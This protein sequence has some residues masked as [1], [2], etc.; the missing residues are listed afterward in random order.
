MPPESPQ[1]TPATIKPIFLLADSQLLFW[2][3]AG[4]VPFLARVRRLLEEDRAGGPQPGGSEARPAGSAGMAKAPAGTSQAGGSH[5]GERHPGGSFKA[6]YLGASNG[7]LREFYELFAGAMA[8]IGI[9]DCRMVPAEPAPADLAHFDAAD[10]ILLAG[11]SVERGW[12]AFRAS[13]L[14]QRIAARYYGG[15]LLI[16][17]SAGAVQLGLKAWSDPPAGDGSGDAAPGKLSLFDTLRLVPFVI[18]AHDEPSWARLLAAVARAGE[19]AR[20]YGIPSGG[21]ALYHP[22]YSVEPVRHA[23]VEVSVTAEGEL[24]QSL[25]VPGAPL[26]DS[27]EGAADAPAADTAAASPDSSAGA[28]D[29]PN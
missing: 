28:A 20:G 18:D 11:G 25:L 21:G 14:D 16:G 29:K 23:L 24:R 17:V 27:A 8:E 12:E 26:A 6:A 9:S 13:G 1:A 10:L 3:E 7:D 22:D 4:G 15:A 2:R 19:H 5:P